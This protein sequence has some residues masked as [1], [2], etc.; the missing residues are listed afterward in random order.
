MPLGDSNPEADPG[1]ES[2]EVGILP[3]VRPSSHED[4]GGVLDS[5]TLIS[6]VPPT[7]TADPSVQVGAYDPEA[8]EDPYEQAAKAQAQSAKKAVEAT[9]FDV[10]PGS[11]VAW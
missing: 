6:R 8:G 4:Q 11:K 10:E 7:A 5:P 9:P 2:G 1:S 3:G